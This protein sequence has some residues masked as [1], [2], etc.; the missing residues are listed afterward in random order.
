M[1]EPTKQD[2]GGSLPPDP[3][4]NASRVGTILAL[5][6][7]GSVRDADMRPVLEEWLNARVGGLTVHELGI[8]RGSSRADLAVVASEALLLVEIKSEH[9]SLTRLPGQV[10]AYSAVADL[11]MLAVAPAHVARARALAPDWWGLVVVSPDERG[12]LVVQELR[13]PAL[14]P[15]LDPRALAELLWREDVLRILAPRRRGLSRLRRDALWDLLVEELGTE[16]LRREV[17]QE[18]R[19]RHVSRAA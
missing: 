10:E 8:L 18:L 13:P 9:D 2:G 11:A 7:G 19:R 16:E 14:N 3:G 4:Q 6:R 12:G 15:R 1:F 17:R 5:L